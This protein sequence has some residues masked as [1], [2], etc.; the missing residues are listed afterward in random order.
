MLIRVHI[1]S[2]FKHLGKG[3]HMDNVHRTGLSAKIRLTIDHMLPVIKTAWGPH[4][5]EKTKEIPTAMK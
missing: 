5:G 2:L 4:T 3:N 1:Y